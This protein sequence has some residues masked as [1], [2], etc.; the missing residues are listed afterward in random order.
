MAQTIRVFS[1]RW[2]G[3]PPGVNVRHP[4]DGVRAVIPPQQSIVVICQ[5]GEGQDGA[6][7]S[8]L[9]ERWGAVSGVVCPSVVHIDALVDL[10]PGRAR[11]G[12]RL[13][14]GNVS[15]FSAFPM[16]V[17]SLSWEMFF[18]QGIQWRKKDG[19]APIHPPPISGFPTPADTA[20]ARSRRMRLRASVVLPPHCRERKLNGPRTLKTGRPETFR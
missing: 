8:A 12:L 6:G 10:V 19:S 15:F 5:L 1:H 20:V 16:F 9:A 17:P 11:Q 13:S 7:C 4:R 2:A 14:C 18:L 3:V